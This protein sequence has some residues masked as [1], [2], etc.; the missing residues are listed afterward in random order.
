MWVLNA[1]LKFES[2]ASKKR[3]KKVPG[4]CLESAWR[5]PEAGS[6]LFLESENQVIKTA[7]DLNGC[8]PG[9]VVFLG[10]QG[11]EF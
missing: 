8:F 1:R 2:V 7:Q 6:H 11:A 3:A 9:L 10:A 4:E 5:V